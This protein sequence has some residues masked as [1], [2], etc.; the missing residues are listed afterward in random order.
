MKKLTPQFVT[1]ALFAILLLFLF[2]Y[3]LA[4]PDGELSQSERRPLKQKPE[5]SYESVEN[6]E[7]FEDFEA[8]ALD[9]AVFREAF[10]SLKAV[11]SRYLFLK[12]DNNGLYQY[13]DALYKIETTNEAS[14]QKA[15]EKI[16]ALAEKLSSL[17][18]YYALIPDKN[19]LIS[20]ESRRPSHDFSLCESLLAEGITKARYIELAP[21]LTVA[22]YY[23]TDLHWRQERLLPIAELL[24]KA[25]DNSV[26]QYSFV[27]TVLSG[28]YGVYHGQ[29]AL[30]L[31]P[32]EMRYLVTS[33]F[34]DVTVESLAS[35]ETIPLYNEEAFLSI[36]P[37][38]L[39]VGG[40]EPLLRMK[41]PNAKT[42]KTLYLF[43][44]SFGSS[45]A[46][47]LLAGYSEIVL[48][49]LRYVDSRYLDY[50]I[51]FEE[52]SDVLFLYSTH[53]LNNS[54]MLR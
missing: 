54:E 42:D 50:F 11:S 18:C 53:I 26:L 6:G 39:Y 51:T 21:Y 13:G 31:D 22:D 52:G 48:I 25:M 10:R 4:K 23:R 24:L 3:Q 47:L 7:Y 38:N 8:Y 33:A 5:F 27:E 1:V 41:N 46:P 16:E 17:H 9:Q 14:F 19:T 29:A 49:D 20:T 44:D 30:P 35:G 45:L 32:D 2:V 36:D 40:T 15:G 43:R 12:G 28:F 34:R 37:Y